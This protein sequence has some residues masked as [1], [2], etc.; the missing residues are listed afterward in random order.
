MKK[1]NEKDNILEVS[2][3]EKIFHKINIDYT[4]LEIKYS[5]NINFKFEFPITP[6]EYLK[7]AQSDIK[8]KGKKGLINAL[9]NSKRSID[10][11]VETILNSLGIA[12]DKIQPNAIKFCNEVLNSKDKNI[13]PQS[14]KLFCALGF[15]PS[16]LISEVRL[17]R[18]KVEHEYEIPNLY[19]V[20]KAVEV[21]ELLLNN[22]KA[23][24]L[25]STSIHITE[26][27]E[28]DTP[29]IYFEES[30]Y[31]KSENNSCFSLLAFNKN[32]NNKILKYEFKGDELIFYFLLK[33]MFIAS[34]DNEL[35]IY[36]IKLMLQ[37]IG[38]KTPKEHIKIKKADYDE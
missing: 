11:L 7:Y 26:C 27:R 33:A 30:H 29:S 37:N 14:L 34:H 3:A 28:G 36:T 21:A 20:V 17:L 16:F 25:Y 12:P 19:D 6:R 18:N 13:E 1:N 8:E 9:S 35:L 5:D 31:I 2:S 24:E 38:T 15:A 32:I 4:N 23:K 10:C 22:V